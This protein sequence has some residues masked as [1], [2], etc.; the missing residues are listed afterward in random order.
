MTDCSRTSAILDQHGGRMVRAV[1][2]VDHVHPAI[3]AA[4]DV[5]DSATDTG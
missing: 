3:L 5:P 1:G 2:T 4:S